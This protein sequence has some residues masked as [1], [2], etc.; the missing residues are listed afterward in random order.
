MAPR[1]AARLAV[2]HLDQIPSAYAVAFTEAVNERLDIELPAPAGHAVDREPRS[3]PQLLA[4]REPSRPP[5]RGPRVGDR[6]VPFMRHTQAKAI[7]TK[8]SGSSYRPKGFLSRWNIHNENS[9]H[10]RYGA[11]HGGPGCGFGG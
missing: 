3:A 8:G 11:F 1:L 6:A 5:L 9:D 2:Q 7:G 4:G 10:R